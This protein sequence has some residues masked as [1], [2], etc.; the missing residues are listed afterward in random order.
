MLI[1]NADELRELLQDLVFSLLFPVVVFATG[2]LW[3]RLVGG[4][5]R[6]KKKIWFS[7]SIAS[8][9]YSL[10][11]TG[12]SDFDTL[13]RLW[14]SSPYV[15]SFLYVLFGL[16]VVGVATIILLRAW[17]PTRHNSERR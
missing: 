17:K 2:A 7:V 6:E 13:K 1:F 16:G 11:R 4:F 9:F 12:Q 10:V 8:L 3:D 5:T 15:F 14:L